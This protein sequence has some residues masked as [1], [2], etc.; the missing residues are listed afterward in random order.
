MY[1]MKTNFD[2]EPNI[3]PIC[4]FDMIYVQIQTFLVTIANIP[5][6]KWIVYCIGLVEKSC[7]EI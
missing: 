1:I 7:T 2:I 4:K 6:Q 3:L 5:N